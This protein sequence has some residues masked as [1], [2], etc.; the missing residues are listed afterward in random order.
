MKKKRMIIMILIIISILAL[1]LGTIKV[2]IDKSY[3]HTKNADEE[4]KKLYEYGDRL[5]EMD[6]LPNTI[7][8]RLNGEEVLFHEIESYRKSINYSI[9]NGST[10]SEGKSAFYEVLVNKLYA[11]LAKE[12]PN[13]STYSL[14]IESNLEKTRNE[15]ENGNRKDSLEEYRKKW[16]DVLAI[17]EDEIWLDD[18]D[19]ITYLQYRSVEQMLSTKGMNI[20]FNFMINR[21]ELANDKILEEKIKALNELKEQQKKLIDE[22]KQSEALELSKDFYNQYN[23]IRKLY[24]RDLIINSDLELCVD[25]GEVSRTIPTIYPEENNDS[26]TSNNSCSSIDTK[27]YSKD[28]K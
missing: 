10:D 20:V 28:M 27:N 26:D 23:E 7:V 16:L 6:I 24:V 4:I 22:N 14:N 12:Y 2:F 21:P 15:W 25:K 3:N 8:A 18:E 19:F 5:E 17:E 11:Y 13:E 9:E 1:I